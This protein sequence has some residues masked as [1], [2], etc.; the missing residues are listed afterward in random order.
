MPNYIVDTSVVADV[1]VSGIYTV[2]AE[3]LM[4]SVD[5]M[6][7]LLVP[8]FCLVECTNVL[9]K[10]VRARGISQAEAEILAD[11]LLPLPLSIASVDKLFKRAL[12]IGL[13]H[14]LAIYDSVYIALAESYQYPLITAD[15]KQETAARTVGVI[16][17][18]ITDF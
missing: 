13:A 9:W 18:P 5:N 16:I 8:G 3:R 12:Q 11:D 10:R 6:T 2:Q 4:L 15:A 14:Q 7:K 1:L 17:K